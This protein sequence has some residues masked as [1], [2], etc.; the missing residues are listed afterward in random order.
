[1]V[2][3]AEAE[4][5]E[6]YRCA[7]DEFGAGLARLAGAYEANAERQRDLLQEI[8]LALWRS[9]ARFKNE[10]SLRTWVYRIA[11]NVAASHVLREQ[12]AQVG[13][14]VELEEASLLADGQDIEAQV[15]DRWMQE[16]LLMMIQRL[17]LPDKQIMHLYLEGCDA[18]TIAEIT[19]FSPANVATKIHRLKGKLAQAFE[20]GDAP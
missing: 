6:L 19:Q 15:G 3:E 18:A 2:T 14:W 16:R 13:K 11:H 12:R 5:E 20:Q 17:R 4:T 7:A 10:C 9:L 1:M 8:H